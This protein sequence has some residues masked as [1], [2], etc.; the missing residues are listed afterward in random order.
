[1]PTALKPDVCLQG[2]VLTDQAMLTAQ[3]RKPLT[4]EYFLTRSLADCLHQRIIFRDNIRTTP[5]AHLTIDYQGN[6]ALGNEAASQLNEHP[7]KQMFAQIKR[8][9]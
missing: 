6:Y 9:R 2:I 1:M 8:E 5:A 3:N 7:E 4:S